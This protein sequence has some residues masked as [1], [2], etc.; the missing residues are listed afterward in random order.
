M[1]SSL[2]PTVVI[3]VMRAQY[4]RTGPP[5]GMLLHLVSPGYAG[6]LRRI[7]PGG[8]IPTHAAEGSLKGLLSVAEAGETSQDCVWRSKLEGAR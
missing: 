2:N 8:R 1:H 5:E 3:R 7:S 4:P 6:Q